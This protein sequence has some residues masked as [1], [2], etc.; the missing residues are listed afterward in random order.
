MAR[1]AGSSVKRHQG[2]RA[3]LQLQI[4]Q[5]RGVL[6]HRQGE[7]QRVDHGVSH[8]V[9]AGSINAIMQQVGNTGG[10]GHEQV[11]NDGIRGQTIDL[12]RHGPVE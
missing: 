4:V 10:F 9:N 5:D 2:I 12:F 11:I 8:V 7:V 1:R 6:G 3:A